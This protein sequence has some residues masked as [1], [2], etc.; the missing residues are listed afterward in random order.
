MT[1]LKLALRNLLG[2]GLRT[3]LRVFVLSVAFVVIVA[4]VGLILGVNEQA[5]QAM[6]AA[7]IGGGQYWQEKYDP[8][9]PLNLPDA[10]AVV[11]PALAE[12]VAEGRATPILA[13]QGF[14]YAGGNF[15]PITLRGIDPNQQVLSVPSSALAGA[16]DF[17]PAL[18]GTRM[19][20]ESGLKAGDTAT[21]R[22]RDARGTF[23][24]TEVQ[25]VEVMN[26]IVQT[27]DSGQIWLPLETLRRM[28]RMDGEAAWIVLDKN[29]AS[30]GTFAGWT[31]RDTDFLLADLRALVRTKLVGQAIAFAMLMFL[32]MLTVLDTQV[33]SIFHRRKEIGTLMALGLTR[34]KVVGVFTMEGALNAVLAALAGALYGFPL[35]GYI[36]ATGIPMPASMDSFGVSMGERIYPAYSTAL[37]LGITLLVLTVTTIVSY[38]PSRQISRMKA[39]DALRGRLT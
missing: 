12:L 1:L 10:H 16:P 39:T 17:V 33:L 2:G 29:T 20:A 22:W 26:T 24:A 18:I 21:V 15:R 30:Q 4:M 14:M 31:F 37:V 13:V 9:D 19:A 25:V 36:V 6:I 34:G 28:A 7:D 11:P 38:L 27:V 32:A 3:W 23:D 8:Q 35:L 5:T